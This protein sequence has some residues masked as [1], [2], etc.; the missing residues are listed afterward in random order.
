MVT[1]R[2]QARRI[3]RRMVLPAPAR[4]RTLT[5]LVPPR[6][7][8][9]WGI[10]CL[11]SY[12]ATHVWRAAHEQHCTK[13]RV[14]DG[15]HRHEFDTIDLFRAVVKHRLGFVPGVKRI[16][17]RVPP[18]MATRGFQALGNHFD[19]ARPVFA[20]PIAVSATPVSGDAGGQEVA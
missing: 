1:M 3:L 8:P 5:V 10:R 18:L 7:M 11:C 9:A 17:G 14:V 2:E 4:D 15:A 19:T 13:I 16:G 12:V 6:V 20:V